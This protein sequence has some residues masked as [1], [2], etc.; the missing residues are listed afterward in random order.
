[1][2]L[3]RYLQAQ[4]AAIQAVRVLSKLTS[5]HVLTYYDS[6]IEKVGRDPALTSRVPGLPCCTA[7]SHKATGE[8]LRSH[9]LRIWGE[10]IAV[11]RY[12]GPDWATRS[13]SLAHSD[14]ALLGITQH[15]CPKHHAPRHQAAEHLSGQYRL[16][17]GG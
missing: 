4:E 14:S 9:R 3:G 11:D 1:M 7:H 12:Q 2:L 5:K 15:P 13:N 16:Y 17:H 6:F 10:P 8:A